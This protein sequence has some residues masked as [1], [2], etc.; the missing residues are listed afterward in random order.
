MKTLI[1]LF[2]T[3]LFGGIGTLDTHAQESIKPSQIRMSVICHGRGSVE[4]TNYNGRL[5]TVGQTYSMYARA[6]AG[7]VFTNW[8]D[9]SGQA[10]TNTPTLRFMMGKNA[11]FI[12]NFVKLDAL[13]GVLA[14]MDTADIP[15]KAL[16]AIN[17]APASQRGQVL[18]KWIDTVAAEK[19]SLLPSVIGTILAQYPGLLATAIESA[20]NADPQQTYAVVY[21]AAK[22]PSVDISELV[23]IA[24]QTSPTQCYQVAQAILDVYPSSGLQILQS[25]SS[26]VPPLHTPI[27]SALTGTQNSLTSSETLS[28]LAAAM[29]TINWP[30]NPSI[31]NQTQYDYAQP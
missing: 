19:P 12:A 28:I 11:V 14:G 5:L 23:S 30:V 8:T 9:G 7:Y 21:T 6:G 1:I 18:A 17:E 2:I 29:A 4:N 20:I 31:H 16:S 15:L 3:A 25:I 27:T 24:T 10:V 13:P 26:S 22:V